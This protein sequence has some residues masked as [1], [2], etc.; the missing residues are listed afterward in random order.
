MRGVALKFEQ[1]RYL[2]HVYL[3]QGYTSAKPI[4][5]QYGILPRSISRYARAIGVKGKQ[6]REP[7]VWKLPPK[8][9]VHRKKVN[10]VV[11]KEVRAPR[12]RINKKDPRWQWAIERGAVS[13]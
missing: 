7:G 13:I 4:A 5:I 3:T 11:Q 12:P 2:L 1:R 9:R 10:G 6:G 8:P